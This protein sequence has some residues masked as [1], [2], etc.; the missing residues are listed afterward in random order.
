M[1]FQTTLGS[2][3]R[4]WRPTRLRSNVT[5]SASSR[6]PTAL[7][8]GFESIAGRH[9]K[10]HNV[11]LIST[12]R[13]FQ[14]VCTYVSGSATEKN[15]KVTLPPLALE[16]IPRGSGACDFKLCG[17]IEVYKDASTY[18]PE[19]FEYTITAQV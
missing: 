18:Y 16:D 19:S 8:F 6:Y 13:G 12:R 7:N 5:C 15:V 17:T 2:L 14:E 3:T 10:I 11:R 9:I 1:Q 4:G